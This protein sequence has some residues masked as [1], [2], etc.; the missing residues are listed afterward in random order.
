MDGWKPHTV[1]LE[2][3]VSVLKDDLHPKI[4]MEGGSIKLSNNYTLASR[5]KAVEEEGWIPMSNSLV[6]SR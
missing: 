1:P 6:Y 2:E 3:P 4:V 5:N